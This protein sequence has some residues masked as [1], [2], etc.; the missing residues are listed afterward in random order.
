MTGTHE[1]GRPAIADFLAM[2]EK[3]RRETVQSLAHPGEALCDWAD[4]V[5]RLATRDV[6]AA[7]AATEALLAAALL[8]AHARA[9]ARVRRARVLALA[10]SGDFAQALS[11]AETS[12]TEA[13]KSGESVEA[14]RA[15]I[16]QMQPLLVTGRAA[17]ALVAGSTARTELLALGEPILAARVDINLGNI[18]KSLG[19]AA[20]AIKALDAAASVLASHP[21][22]AAH[23]ANAR[24]EALFL[25]DRFV[26]ARQAFSQALAHFGPAGGMAS[27]VVEGNLADVASRQGEYQEAL[28]GFAKARAQLGDAPSAHAARMY[29]EEGEVF[30]MLGITEVASERYSKGLAMFDKL[31]MAYEALRAAIGSGRVLESAGD[32]EA[33]AIAFEHA[34]NRAAA[35][36]NETE[37]SR[38]LAQRAST[39]AKMGRV[40]EANTAL[41]AIV[42]ATLT[43]PIDQAMYHFH[44]GVVAERAGGLAQAMT[45]AETALAHAAV[46]GVP[47]VQADALALRAL[48]LRRAQRPKEAASDA[49]RAVAIVER[50]RG[51]LQAERTRAGLLG[52]RL[53]AYEELVAALMADGSTAAMAEAFAVA[54]QA[55]S[56]SLLDRMRQAIGS[57]VAPTAGA[58]AAE[59]AELRRRLDALYARVADDSQKGIR[60]GLAP[61]VRTQIAEIETRIGFIEAQEPS[62]HAAFGNALPIDPAALATSIPADSAMIA[63]Y[64]AKG[65]WMAFVTTAEGTKAISLCCDDTALCDALGRLGFQL[66]RGLAHAGEMRPRLVSDAVSCLSRVASLVWDPISRHVQGI[67][68]L[69]LL[70]HGPLHTLPFHALVSN[71]RFI[72]HT[73]AVSYAPSANTWS[74][75]HNRTATAGLGTGTRV[76][77]VPDPAAPCIER[78][79]RAVAQVVGDRTPLIGAE[80]T[81]QRVKE[82]L[83]SASTVHLA[84]HGFFLP[85]APRASGLKLSDGWLTAR[86]IASLKRTP[87]TVVLSGCETAATAV[88]EGDELLGLAS[89]FLGNTT[90][91]LLATL[92]PVH[93]GRAADAMTSFYGISDSGPRPTA[94]RIAQRLSLE[95]LERT[96]HPAH[97]A[98]FALIGA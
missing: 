52:K 8:L 90:N 13:L 12:R 15:L 47:P 14:A 57:P 7:L 75:L 65:Q 20:E 26:E 35:L 40:G 79:A 22:L 28:E 72:A 97:W 2:S 23:I 10:Y 18:H 73:H 38:A 42:P 61:E 17:D 92:W 1:D 91:Q 68:N 59:L 44:R 78:E 98:P 50:M 77:G 9:I 83:T 69:I 60:H 85:E 29:A 67:S 74:A 51:S 58:A 49:R 80:A 24:G 95:L 41:D 30:E 63:Y 62:T 88:R 87:T 3:A 56:R 25:L 84:C 70:P 36:G 93:D 4:E 16:A 43:A 19:N 64:R 11:L 55:K 86:D 37:R 89:A 94:A 66:R 31:G 21:D 82:C 39:L 46:A 5:D 96:P 71:G 6:P 32:S 34:A 45:E 27:A 53:G 76:I 81:I 33:G 48:L 54:E